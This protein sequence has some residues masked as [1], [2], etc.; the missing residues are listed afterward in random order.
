MGRD[1][2]L[3]NRLAGCE[4]RAHQ[5]SELVD[6][7]YEIRA[8]ENNVPQAQRPAL[9]PVAPPPEA[10]HGVIVHGYTGTPHFRMY[11][12]PESIIESI[13]RDPTR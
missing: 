10:Q 4:G 12:P 1:N 2:E 3:S 7:L 6:A 5:L 9:R 8:A 13:Y 11:E